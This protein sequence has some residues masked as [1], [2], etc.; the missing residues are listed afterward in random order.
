M[1]VALG[2]QLRSFANVELQRAFNCLL[3]NVQFPLPSTIKNRL[4]TRSQEVIPLL[5]ERLPRGSSKVSLALD[6]WSSFN[7]QGYLAIN[8]YFIDDKWNY[9]EV[10]L[11][12]KQVEG[13]H[14]GIKLAEVL[15]SVFLKIFFYS[16]SVLNLRL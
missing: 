14:P 2:L 3:D 8:A 4:M 9:Y 16:L 6:F 15:N 5:L 7:R 11:A 1:I 12:S 10:L 13:S